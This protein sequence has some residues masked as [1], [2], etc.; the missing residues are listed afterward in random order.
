[1][2][3][4][5]LDIHICGP[6]GLPFWPTSTWEMRK[7]GQSVSRTRA[8]WHSMLNSSCGFTRR[9]CP[10]ATKIHKTVGSSASLSNHFFGDIISGWW[11]QPLWKIWKSVGDT[12]PNIW[13]NKKCSKP[14]TR[15]NPFSHTHK[16]IYIYIT[17]LDPHQISAVGYDSLWHC[18]Q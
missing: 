2:V 10:R 4:T 16:F 1:M 11:F 12:I 14:T 7:M 18:Q 6:L 17:C 13:K 15:Y 9:L 5:K 8:D 3:N